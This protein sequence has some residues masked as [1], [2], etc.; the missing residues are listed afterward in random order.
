MVTVVLCVIATSITYAALE[1]L[2]LR[3]GLLVT[4]PVFSRKEAQE[5]YE[6]SLAQYTRWL[7]AVYGRRSMV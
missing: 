4:T 5:V 1:R 3:A 2:L 7:D 6:A